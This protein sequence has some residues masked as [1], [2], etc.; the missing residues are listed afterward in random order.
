MSLPE[1]LRVYGKQFEQ[2]KRRF[3]DGQ[4]GRCAMG[5]IMSYYGWDGHSD[6]SKSMKIALNSLKEADIRRSTIIK[7]NDS[8]KTFDE[9]AE[10]LDRRNS[11]WY[12]YEYRLVLVKKEHRPLV[13]IL[14]KF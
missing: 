4:N 12:D 10:Y 6:T 3:S 1:I 9:I 7:L 2:I 14:K 13:V 5:L 8:G 11:R